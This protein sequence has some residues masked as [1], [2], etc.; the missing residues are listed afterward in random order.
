MIHVDE[1]F[2]KN[3]END[4]NNYHDN[5]STE[6]CIDE[7][8]AQT[9]STIQETL[10]K[11]NSNKSD[12]HEPLSHLSE[13]TLIAPPPP[14]PPSIIHIDNSNQETTNIPLEPVSTNQPQLTFSKKN[15]TISIICDDKTWSNAKVLGRGGKSTGK[16]KNCINVRLNDTDQCINLDKVHWKNVVEYINMVQIPKSDNNKEDCIK[17]KLEELGKLKQ[18]NTYDE[19]ADTGQFCISTKWV[20]WKKRGFNQSLF[21]SSG[22]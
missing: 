17:A 4:Q 15:D 10:G 19:V 21:S 8:T 13:A 11:A 22:L 5:V 20:L 7:S 18:L 6:P 14:P 3:P 12:N 16:H 2:I 1:Q 9:K